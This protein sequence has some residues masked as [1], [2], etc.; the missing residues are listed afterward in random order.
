MG[1][2]AEWT[3]ILYLAPPIAAATQGVTGWALALLTIAWAWLAAGSYGYHR[4]EDRLWAWLDVTGMIAAITSLAPLALSDWTL[5]VLPVVWITY[6][7]VPFQNYLRKKGIRNG[8]VGAWMTVA[9]LAHAS[10]SGWYSLI[11]L[12]IITAAVTVRIVLSDGED[13]WHSIW[14]VLSAGAGVMYIALL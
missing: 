12:G 11:P 13:I 4:Y 7:V 1:R 10:K 14:H 3:N 6:L 8:H 2:L 9:L 5:Y